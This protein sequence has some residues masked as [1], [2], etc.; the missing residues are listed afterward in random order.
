[1]Q[2]AVDFLTTNEGVSTEIKAYASLLTSVIVQA[3]R[4]LAE[5]PTADEMRAERNYEEDAKKSLEFFFGRHQKVFRLYAQFVG[6][7]AD[8]YLKNLESGQP[9][10]VKS[11]PWTHQDF[12]VF[13]ARIS[14]WKK[15]QQKLRQWRE[16][17][18]EQKNAVKEQKAANSQ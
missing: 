7:N 8:A 1:M 6:I 3:T 10:D 13:R 11:P 16:R 12:R 4:D 17:S 9:L 18:V 14:W 2:S 15:E 5:K